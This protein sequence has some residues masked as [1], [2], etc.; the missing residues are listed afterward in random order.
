M[1]LTLS[2]GESAGAISVFDHTIINGGDN[3]YNGKALFRGAIMNSGSVVPSVDVDAPKAQKVYDAVV[4]KAGCSS[5]SDTLTC[6]RSVDYTTLL[7]AAN[8]VP[9]ILSYTSVD[10]SY[11]PRPDPSDAFFPKSPDTALD[12]FA[13]VPI[14]IGDQEDEGTLFALFQNNLTTT[15]DVVNYLKTYFPLTDE[16]TVRGLVDLYPDSA[17]AGSP[18]NTGIFNQLYPQFKRLASILGDATFIL[19]RRAYLEQVSSQV[20][21]WS[22]L[23]SY[24]YG[25]PFL[26]TGHGTDIL[27]LFFNFNIPSIPAN[28]ILTYYISFVNHLDPNAISTSSPLIQWPQY[29]TTHKQ[30]MHFNLLNND[31]TTDDFRSEAYQ[32]LVQHQSV[33]RVKQ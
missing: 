27:P 15:E 20:K 22:Y 14:I 5:S 11:L 3:T 9:G 6:L 8:S 19:S 29:T 28:S 21:S 12:G 16:K 31:L 24:F 13:K 25:L 17:S 32:Y 10:L 2:R 30:L 4:A 23:S 1:K 26:G 33:L 7:N 18:Y